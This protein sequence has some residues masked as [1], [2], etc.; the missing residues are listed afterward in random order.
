VAA[1]WLGLAGLLFFSLRPA[2]AN[3]GRTKG[4]P[5]AVAN[6]LNSHDFL[7]NYL[8]YAGMGI[9]GFSLTGAFISQ[10]QRGGLAVRMSYRKVLIRMAALVVAIEGAQIWIPGRVSD[11]M[12]VLSAWSGLLT[13][14]VA[15]LLLRKVSSM[16]RF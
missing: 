5:K 6:W 16:I 11:P 12:D 10:K 8:A 14:W 2:Y 9:L 1:F 13:S 4:L 15:V 7:A 3:G